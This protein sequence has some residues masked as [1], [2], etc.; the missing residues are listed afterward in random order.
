[1]LF[2]WPETLAKVSFQFQNLNTHSI[3]SGEMI[4]GSSTCHMRR[5]S[6][7]SLRSP[8]W[9]PALS[10]TTLMKPKENT[11]PGPEPFPG[12]NPTTPSKPIQPNPSSKISF[13]K[14]PTS[15]A[16]QRPNL[17]CFWIRELNQLILFIQT[18]LKTKMI[19]NGPPK[20]RFKLPLPIQ[21]TNS[22]K[23]RKLPQKWRSSGGW[24]SKKTLETI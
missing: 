10:S 13:N 12:S 16:P 19:L 9:K 2:H 4:K 8:T 6:L 21:L 23:S 14:A 15:T 18:L 1:M 7:T 17:S 11:E 20:T 22:E 3:S 24:P 5:K